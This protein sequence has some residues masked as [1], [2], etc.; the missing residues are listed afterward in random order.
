MV[1]VGV[2]LVVGGGAGYGFAADGAEVAQEGS[3]GEACGAGVVVSCGAVS[4]G[5]SAA[6]GGFW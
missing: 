6:F 2:L 4:E 3:A 1:Q 5:F